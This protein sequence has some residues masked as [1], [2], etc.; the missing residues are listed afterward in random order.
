MIIITI[1]ILI[2]NINFFFF[3]IEVKNCFVFILQL[4]EI[5]VTKQ[6][7]FMKT[8]RVLQWHQR[9]GENHL[10]AGIV[11]ELF[12]ALPGIGFCE[13]VSKSSKL[14]YLRMQQPVLE[15]T[16]RWVLFSIYF[17]FL[18]F[19]NLCQ[20]K[21]TSSNRSFTLIFYISFL[22]FFSIRN[23]FYCII[24]TIIF[25]IIIMRRINIL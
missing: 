4:S 20:Q 25:L 22:L 13:F 3:W 2:I 8:C 17:T 9:L 16:Y 15:V 6:W 19:T 1:I 21:F 10:L 7:T 12:V 14:A 18:L 24:I 11:F 5:I 23:C